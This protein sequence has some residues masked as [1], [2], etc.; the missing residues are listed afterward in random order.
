LFLKSKKKIFNFEKTSHNLDIEKAEKLFQKY[1][2]NSDGKI[3]SNELKRIAEGLLDR[4]VS[5]EE[6][7]RAVNFFIF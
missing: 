2:T 3:D 4:Q 7:F 1:D 6:I 5:N